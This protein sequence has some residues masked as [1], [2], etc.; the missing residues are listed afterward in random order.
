[1]ILLSMLRKILTVCIMDRVGS[2]LDH[3][4]PIIQAVYRK[5][6]SITEHVVAGKMAIEQ[7]TN[8]RN[9]TLHL[10]L[11]NMSKAFDSIK[12]KELIE[13]LQDYI[14]ADELHIMKK[15]LEVSLVVRCG[16]SISEPFHTDTSAPQGYCA[17]ANSFTY[18][19]AKSLMMQSFMT[20]TI[21]INLSLVMKYQMSSLRKIMY[22][23]RK[24]NISIL[25]WSMLMILTSLPLTTTTST[26][27]NIMWK[28]ILAKK[29]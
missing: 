22:N 29:D 8:E 1:M 27:T 15:M 12:R 13:H 6:M 19:L 25:K 10:V 20:I 5:K 14:A 26:D 24:S 2:T 9:E 17:S 11:L 28:K 18:F 21:I 16:D 3:E 4:T 7:T 23:Q